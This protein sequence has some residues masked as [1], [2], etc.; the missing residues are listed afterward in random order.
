MPIQEAWTK[1]IEYFAERYFII[2]IIS[3]F[4]FIKKYFINRNFINKKSR[5]LTWKNFLL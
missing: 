3:Y 1:K 2:L 4:L 5:R